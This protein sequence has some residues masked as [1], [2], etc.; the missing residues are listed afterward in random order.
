METP[1][2]DL[3]ALRKGIRAMQHDIESN[4]AAI[5]ELKSRIAEYEK[6]IAVAEALARR[7]D[8]G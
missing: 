7:K 6:H 4:E 1:A 2:Y 8:G 5:A 3:E